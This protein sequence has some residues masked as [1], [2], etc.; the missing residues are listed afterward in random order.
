MKSIVS[1]V[2]KW[3]RTFYVSKKPSP[4]I[5]HLVLS[6][7]CNYNCYFCYLDPE[8]ERY[9]LP[10]EKFEELVAELKVLGTYYLYISGGEPLLVKD[11][12]RYLSL[13]ADS[14]P[15]LHIVTNGSLLDQT[16]ACVI[17]RCGVNEVSLSLDAM[18]KTHNLYRRNERAFSRVIAGIENLKR[19]APKVTITC[20]TVIAPWNIEE[21][22][23][24]SKL[25]N[26]LGVKQRYQAI[27]EYPMVIKKQEGKSLITRE[28]V[29]KLKEFIKGLPHEKVDR[30]LNLQLEYFSHLTEGSELRHP[31]FHDPCLLP[32]FYV[33]ILGSGEVSPCYGVKSRLYPGTGYVNPPKEFNIFHN[34]LKEIMEDTLYQKMA[35]ELQ[36]CTECR[37]YFA[38]CYIRPRLSFPIRNEIRYHLRTFN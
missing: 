25:C 14:I 24:L 7:I 17:N 10:L 34:A 11:I 26:S 38:S 21:Q 5:T 9:T 31:I 30:Y 36:E 12:E 20:T 28:F 2:A 29:N 22:A 3:Y 19:F 16:M 15:Y 37:R 6:N 8:E 27:Q 32:Y 4:L 35:H 23:S 13:A 18:E 33:N 1:K